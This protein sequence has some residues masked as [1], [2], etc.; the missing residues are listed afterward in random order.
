[1]KKWCKTKILKKTRKTA[2]TDKKMPK[3][4]YVTK[5]GED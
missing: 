3:V 2:K 5:I 4:I 1:M